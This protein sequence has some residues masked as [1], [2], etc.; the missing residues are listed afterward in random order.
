MRTL[1]ANAA[2]TADLQ[3]AARLAKSDASEAWRHEP[4]AIA[5]AAIIGLNGEDT[6]R[7]RAV[8]AEAQRLNRRHSLIQGIVLE[9]GLARQDY[10]VTIRAMDRLLRTNPAQSTTFFPLL[11]QALTYPAAQGEMVRIVDGSADWHHR[12]LEFAVGRP[13]ALEGLARYRLA[14]RFAVP[15]VDRLLVS[16]LAGQGRLDLA[17][18][19]HGRIDSGPGSDRRQRWASDYAP[20]DWYL[21][22]EPGLRAQPDAAGEALELFVRGGNGGVLARRMIPQELVAK[23]VTLDIEGIPAGRNDAAQL[24]IVCAETGRQAYEAPLRNGAATYAR[25]SAGA[26][27]RFPQIEL[28]GR[29][30]TGEPALR[31]RVADPKG[32]I[33]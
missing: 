20:F 31:I 10:P 6:A 13:T 23:G 25:G 19:V 14:T 16:G 33:S 21:A 24:A 29:S 11:A 26:Q 8:M 28:R 32:A 5:A 27:C 15:Q 2:E 7:R 9:D 3:R 4:L 1:S 30:F 12:F 22:D 18:R 17:Q